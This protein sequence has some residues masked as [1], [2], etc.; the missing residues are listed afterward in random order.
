MKDFFLKRVFIGVGAEFF[1]NIG[2]GG[3]KDIH[4]RALSFGSHHRGDGVVKFRLHRV[5]G[6]V[7]SA[8]HQFFQVRFQIL[9]ADESYV[10]HHID[11]KR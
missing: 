7:C 9:D 3:V 1:V 6:F 8:L 4:Y 5:C 2:I 11:R 10:I